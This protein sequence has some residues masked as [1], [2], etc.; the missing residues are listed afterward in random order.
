MDAVVVWV[1]IIAAGATSAV[2]L[3]ALG[4]VLW[5]LRKQ[6]RGDHREH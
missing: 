1:L 6:L 2:A 4:A 3:L 5:G